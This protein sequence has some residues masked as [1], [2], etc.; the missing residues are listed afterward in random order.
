M[1]ALR[2][3]QQR[4]IVVP[5]HD[6]KRFWSDY[7]KF[8]TG[9]NPTLVRWAFNVSRCVAFHQGFSFMLNWFCLSI[10]LRRK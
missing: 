8:E 9:I 5:M 1:L 6:V 3:A 2:R 10:L 7:V 4:A